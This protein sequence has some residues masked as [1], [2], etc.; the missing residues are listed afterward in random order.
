[1]FFNATFNN[2]SVLV[3]AENGVPRENHRP[4]ASQSQNLSH[5]VVSSTPRYERGSISQP[6]VCERFIVWFL[7]SVKC[8]QQ[9]SWIDIIY[10]GRRDRMVVLFTTTSITDAFSA[11]HH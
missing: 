10:R 8:L 6:C 3:V 4:G 2:I 7:S 5:N 9:L 1:M 11:Y